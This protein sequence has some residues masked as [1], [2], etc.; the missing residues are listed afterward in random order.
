[1]KFD[2]KVKS[3]TAKEII[4]TMVESLKNP[5]TKIDMTTFGSIRREECYGCAATNTICKLGDVSLDDLFLMGGWPH[6]EGLG[7][8]GLFLANFEAAIDFLRRGFVDDYNDCAIRSGFAT[9][10]GKYFQLPV[11]E[12]YYTEKELSCYIKLAELQEKIL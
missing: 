6:A 10:K 4:M 8:D 7:C 11:L 12:T 9:I 5:V 3:L 1:M 2:D